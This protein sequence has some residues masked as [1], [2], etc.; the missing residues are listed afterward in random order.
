MLCYLTYLNFEIFDRRC[1]VPVVVSGF[2]LKLK[3][4]SSQSLDSHFP[5]HLP[6]ALLLVIFPSKIW[7]ILPPWIVGVRIQIVLPQEFDF[8]NLLGS[9]N[10]VYS[11]VRTLANFTN[12][13][14][15]LLDLSNLLSTYIHSLQSL[16][17]FRSYN[18]FN[19]DF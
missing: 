15:S 6:R 12:Y 11:L 9:S 14:L 16:F 5:F 19:P 10:T 17:N 3:A 13:R 8:F 4:L 2:I 18:I 7:M 1:S